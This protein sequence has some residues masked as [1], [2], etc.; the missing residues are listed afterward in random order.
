MTRLV[1]EFR[2]IQ[3]KSPQTRTL[4]LPADWTLRHLFDAILSAYSDP[5]VL[6]CDQISFADSAHHRSCGGFFEPHPDLD[7][8]KGMSMEWPLSDVFSDPGTIVA[9]RCVDA[10]ADSSAVF[11]IA[12]LRSDDGDAPECL[13]AVG[14]KSG[15]FKPR[16]AQINKELRSIPSL[17]EPAETGDEDDSGEDDGEDDGQRLDSLYDTFLPPRGK[18]LWRSPLLPPPPP[19]AEDLQLDDSPVD[20]ALHR[21]ACELARRVWVLAPWNGLEEEALV[22][23]RLRD[24]RE[25]IL[26]VMGHVGEYHALAFYPD[27]PTFEA[28]HAISPARTPFGPNH[29]LAFWQWQLAFLKKSELLPGE[30]DAVKASG[31]PFAR[32][33]LPSFECMAPGFLPHPA[34]GRELADLV[35]LLESAVALFSDAKAMAALR[36][37]RPAPGAVLRWANSDGAFGR[38][39]PETRP[40]ELRFPFDLPPNLLLQLH[41]LPLQDRLVSFGEIAMPVGGGKSPRQAV[42][43]LVLAVDEQTGFAMKPQ[44]GKTDDDA[45]PAL[46]RPADLLADIARTILASPLNAF[47]ARL[48][49][50]GDFMA[51]FL[52]RLAELRGDGVRFDPDAPCHTLLEFHDQISSVLGR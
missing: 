19:P 51:L 26:S 10:F 43:P 22:A 24:G 52:R 37:H 32:G 44:F 36:R 5:E 46:F 30:A 17:H 45:P 18:I 3:T 23:F 27:L 25:R 49:S 48:A 39:V 41:A 13:E 20:P 38:L 34:G 42:R 8:S 12:L 29:L 35:D 16:C 31:V 4:A 2:R 7:W 6:D 14:P 50:P 33:H 28:I 47:P 11:S 9:C 15:P 40:V 21:R 1:L